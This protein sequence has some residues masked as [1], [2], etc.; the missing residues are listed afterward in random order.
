M[1]PSNVT[2][3]IPFDEGGTLY[4]DTPGYVDTYNS[5]RSAFRTM[6]MAPDS[7]ITVNGAISVG[8]KHT[9]QMGKQGPSGPY[10]L[11]AVPLH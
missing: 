6:T 7:S 2:L 11:R 9:Y 10:G 5:S 4:K 1:I 8:G 3:L